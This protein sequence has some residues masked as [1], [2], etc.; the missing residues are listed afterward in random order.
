MRST[1]PRQGGEKAR[2]PGLSFI[3]VALIFFLPAARAPGGGL[4]VP[5][6]APPLPPPSGNVVSVSTVGELQSAVAALASNTTVLVA[7]GN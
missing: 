4:T 5:P 1:L 3:P 2:R 6:S 7:P